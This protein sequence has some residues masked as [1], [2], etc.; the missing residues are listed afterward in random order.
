MTESF[1][2]DMR[3]CADALGFVLDDYKLG[4]LFRYYEMLIEKNKVMNLTSI[5]EEADVV[6]KHFI[7]SLS[8]VKIFDLGSQDG[9][10][11]IDIGTGAGFPGLVLKIVF[12]NVKVTLFDSLNKR[13]NFLNDVIDELNLKDVYTVHG[14]AEDFAHKDGFRESFDLVVSRAVANLSTLS[15]LCIPFVKKNGVFIAYKSG[16]C[17]EELSDSEKAIRV[18]GGAVYNT[19]SFFIPGTDMA[20]TLIMIKKSG[21]T[22]KKY[23][24]KAGLP[25]KIP[26]K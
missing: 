6:R 15:E 18:M 26:I 16:N 2:K 4:L 24:R 20:R 8:I 9:L 14:R 7:D 23:P 3:F 5:T 17:F 21:L 12:D 1:V 19:E 11:L 13:L 25:G 22:P 10:S